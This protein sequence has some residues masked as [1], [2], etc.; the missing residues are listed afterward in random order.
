MKTTKSKL[1]GGGVDSISKKRG[2]KC[3][4]E[5]HFQGAGFDDYFA[6]STD[7]IFNLCIIME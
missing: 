6:S 1:E 2:K 3:S 5:S 7:S 4:I